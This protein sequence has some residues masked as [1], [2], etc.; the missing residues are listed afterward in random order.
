LAADSCRSK[1]FE[2]LRMVIPPKKRPVEPVKAEE[3][4]NRWVPKKKFL[5]PQKMSSPTEELQKIKN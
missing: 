1:I 3:I 5:A 2:E 4:F